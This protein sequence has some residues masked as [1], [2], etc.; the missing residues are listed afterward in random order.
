MDNSSGE[1]YD[2]IAFIY[3]AVAGLA[4]FNQINKSQLAFLSNI[5]TQDTCLIIGGGTGYFLQKLLE[6]NKTIQVTYVEASA[7]MLALAQ[8]RIG[9]N[10]PDA[11]ARVT[12][13]CT[14]VEDVAWNRYDVIVCNYFLDL[15]TDAQVKDFVSIFKTQLNPQGVLYITDFH[16]PETN[17]FLK[18]GTQLGLTILYTL[19]RFETKMSARALPEIETILIAQGFSIAHAKNYLNGILTCSLYRVNE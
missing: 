7:K 2:R 15:F 11:A 8:K 10:I 13:V 14:R 5:S 12:F 18:W 4:S 6:A 16:I 19:F 17:R 1:G 9:K 3:D